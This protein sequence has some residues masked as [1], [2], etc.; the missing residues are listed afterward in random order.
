MGPFLYLSVAGF[1]PRYL[2]RDGGLGEN[3]LVYTNYDNR[4]RFD[5][6]DK[7]GVQAPATNLELIVTWEDG[8]VNTYIASAPF[9]VDIAPPS[10]VTTGY[11]RGTVDIGADKYPIYPFVIVV[12][13]TELR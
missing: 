10:G 11:A 7:N 5:V 12:V 2:A 13:N 6:L 8:G 3:L 9:Q 1:P 4:T